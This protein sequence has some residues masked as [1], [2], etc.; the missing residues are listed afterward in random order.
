MGWQRRV[1]PFASLPSM[2]CEE[3]QRR[4]A[5]VFF[6]QV[7]NGETI[8]RRL[9]ASCAAPIRDHIPP[10]S[11]PELPHMPEARLF[12]LAPD[13]SRP[14]RVA[15]PDPV[16][17]RA[18]ASSVHAKPFEIIRD[19]MSL[20]IFVSISDEVSFSTAALLCS[21]YGITTTKVA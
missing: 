2:I 9:C 10:E 4:E 6:T 18:L 21:R 11:T 15:I 17:V 3:C 5:T 7:I 20:N 16:A 12:S 1:T 14:T 19:F 13:P 8:K